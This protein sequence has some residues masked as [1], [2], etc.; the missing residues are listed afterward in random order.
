MCVHRGNVHEVA[1]M[2]AF[3]EEL[4][5]GCFAHFNFIPVGRGLKMVSGDITRIGDEGTYSNF[6]ANIGLGGNYSQPTHY[7]GSRV[8]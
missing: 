1:E 6:L 4:G 8:S 2:I 3:A 7:E 5:A